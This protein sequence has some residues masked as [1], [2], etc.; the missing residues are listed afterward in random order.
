MIISL[1]R[2]SAS[3]PQK[4]YH[5]NNFIYL[6]MQ[7]NASSWGSNFFSNIKWEKI[8]IIDKNKQD[9]F[10]SDKNIIVFLRHPMDRWYSGIAEYFARKQHIDEDQEF[11]LNKELLDLIFSA[12]RL[13]GHS[14]LQIK[15]LLGLHL[16]QCTFFNIQD[17][18][19]EYNVHRFLHQKKLISKLLPLSKF[20]PT[21]T[22]NISVMKTSIIK[23]LKDHA[24]QYPFLLQNISSFYASDFEFFYWLSNNDLFFKV[25]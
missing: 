5:K 9:Q 10:I 11:I 12:V 6:P 1:T 2:E 19:F 20:K 25:E 21:H 17:P 3:R 18:S 4:I 8:S 23:Q 16:N 13:D 15:W 22:S 7:K 24:V 14:D